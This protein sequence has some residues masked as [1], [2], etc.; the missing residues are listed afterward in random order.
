M[1]RVPPRGDGGLKRRKDRLSRLTARDDPSPPPFGPLCRQSARTGAPPRRRPDSQTRTP[2]SRLSQIS[3]SSCP[4]ANVK[5]A[6]TRSGGEPSLG[7]AS[8]TTEPSPAGRALVDHAR[9]HSGHTLPP[10]DTN[11]RQLGPV[12]PARALASSARLRAVRQ[13]ACHRSAQFGAVDRGQVGGLAV[14]SGHLICRRSPG[15]LT[16]ELQ[17]AVIA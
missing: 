1:G 17:R 11:C 8:R 7:G 3:P 16:P 5:G 4:P 10:L 9:R 12:P 13:P 14:C 6:A 15:P 2:S